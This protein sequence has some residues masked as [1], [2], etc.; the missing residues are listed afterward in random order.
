MQSLAISFPS[1]VLPV[2]ARKDFSSRSCPCRLTLFFPCCDSFLLVPALR[3]VVGT[4]RTHPFIDLGQLEFPKPADLVCGQALAL[5]PAVDGV[6][7]DAQMLSDCAG[8]DPR[9][10]IQGIDTRAYLR[11]VSSRHQSNRM[12]VERTFRARGHPRR[13]RPETR[14][15]RGFSG[16]KKGPQIIRALVDG[17]EDEDRTHDLCIANAALS[18]LSYPPMQQILDTT[19][20]IPFLLPKLV[21]PPQFGLLG[22]RGCTK[23]EIFAWQKT[24]ADRQTVIQHPGIRNGDDP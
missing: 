16:E 24:P 18:Q 10:G 21:N 20:P 6:F 19:R 11:V 1:A 8:G 14:V 2:T 23:I 3:R 13:C 12:P 9:F 22:R 4:S 5:A 15:A 7:H 17:G